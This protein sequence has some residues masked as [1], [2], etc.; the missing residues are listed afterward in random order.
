MDLWTGLS[1][2]A[3]I[4]SGLLFLWMLIDMLSVGKN[5]SE[6]FLLSSREGEE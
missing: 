1:W 5:Y 2:A 3:W 4:V 6:D